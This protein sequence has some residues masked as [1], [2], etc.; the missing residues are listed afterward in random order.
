MELSTPQPDSQLKSSL[1]SLRLQDKKLSL[2]WKQLRYGHTYFHQLHCR[3]QQAVSGKWCRKFRGHGK[4]MQPRTKVNGSWGT[5]PKKHLPKTPHILHTPQFRNLKPGS[6]NTVEQGE[7]GSR[8]YLDNEGL[9][10]EA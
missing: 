5:N 3:D 1:S 9:D 7:R 4:G 2:A 10:S 6:L 8:I